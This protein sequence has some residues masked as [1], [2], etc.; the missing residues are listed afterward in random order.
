MKT[1]F[2]RCEG[3]LQS[4]GERS[5]WRQRDTAPEPT[6]SGIV[7][8]LG[9]ALGEGNDEGLRLL[10]LNLRMGVRCDRPGRLLR[11]FHTVVAKT[12]VSNRFY[13]ADA[14]FLVALQGDGPLLDRLEGA[15][16][17][18]V[19]P[20]FLGRKACVPSLPP[21]A[22]RGEFASLR[23]A[24]EGAP[25]AWRGPLAR[26]G[27]P[28][29]VRA[30]LEAAPHGGTLRKDELLSNRYRTFAAR[31]TRDEWLTLDPSAAPA[32]EGAPG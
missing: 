11:D 4:W 32:V 8:L 27:G 1:L 3:P 6:K 22:G 29:R 23:E 13:L 17:D 20:I 2:V 24:L 12:V 28:V 25:C 7:G 16:R 31:W 9:C 18:P 30:V 5:R 19:W 14:S 10:S 26:T 15:L 21:F